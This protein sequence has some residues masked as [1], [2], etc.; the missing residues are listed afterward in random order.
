MT[1]TVQVGELLYEV[2]AR[3][4]QVTEYGVGMADVL[5]G[6]APVPAAG[7]RFDVAF[8]GSAR[9]PKL[10]GTLVGV[11]YLHVR[12]DGRFELHIHAHVTTEDGEHLSFFADGVAVPQAGTPVAQLRE[13]GSFITASPKYAWLNHVQ[14]W[15]HG[16]VDPVEGQIRV[17]GYAA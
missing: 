10:A 14:V 6:K 17:K 16:T 4:T 2:V 15:A 5:G 1:A 11:D 12:A 13:S 3:F 8:E 9:G 7:A